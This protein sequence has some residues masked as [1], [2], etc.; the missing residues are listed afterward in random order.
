MLSTNAKTSSHSLEAN[1]AIDL[2][3]NCPSTLIVAHISTEPAGK[4][5][6]IAHWKQLENEHTFVVI[7]MPFLQSSGNKFV[8]L[9]QASIDAF[10]HNSVKYIIVV[11]S[12]TDNTEL[13]VMSTQ[14]AEVSYF[15]VDN[16][17]TK[18]QKISFTVHQLETVSVTSLKDLSG[19]AITANKP[20]AVFSGSVCTDLPGVT[21]AC[22]H[23]VKQMPQ[24]NALG[25][26]HVASAFL[27]SKTHSTLKFVATTHTT[28]VNFFQEGDAEAPIFSF[29]PVGV[30]MVRLFHVDVGRYYMVESDHPILISHMNSFHP[31]VILVPNLSLLQN[32]FQ[33]F[34]IENSSVK[35]SHYITIIVPESHFN[36]TAIA[37]DD[38]PLTELSFLDAPTTVSSNFCGSFTV[39]DMEVSPGY[40]VLKH[41]TPGAGLLLNVYGIANGTGYGYSFGAKPEV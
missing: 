34:C 25:R 39:I 40:H 3:L 16:P 29:G 21:G 24:V 35:I 15:D 19:T 22:N 27:G 37:I 13:Q 10:Q 32:E 31:F 18:G 7:P 14:D 8:I 6:I 41:T 9:S 33:F 2:P 36:I 30:G 1:S 38:V 23:A 11:I 5:D 4:V 26:C 20:I 12:Y 17:L 28:Y